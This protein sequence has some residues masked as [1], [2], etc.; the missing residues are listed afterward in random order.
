VHSPP[1]ASEMLVGA[2]APGQVRLQVDAVQ[3]TEHDPAAHVTSHLAAL[4][5]DTVLL[6]PTFKVQSALSQVKTPLG[7]A[8]QV[9]TLCAAQAP[10]QESAQ[11]PVQVLTSLQVSAPPRPASQM[12][13]VPALQVHI[14]PEQL[15]YWP[16]QGDTI[17]AVPHP[18]PARTAA[19]S[20]ARMLSPLT[21]LPRIDPSLGPGGKSN[22]RS[23][24][25]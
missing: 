25:A 2:V 19:T 7:P 3:V 22:L 10:L 15:Q 21:G 9:Q 4:V 11:V 1:P 18:T 14:A 12:Q 6:V 24:C 13:V 5:H 8:V 17:V 23:S 20:S 16:G